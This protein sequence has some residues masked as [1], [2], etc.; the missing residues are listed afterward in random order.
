MK[1]SAK[2]LFIMFFIPLIGL[3]QQK[4]TLIKKVDSLRIKA[5]TLKSDR[6]NN[7]NPPGMK[8][9]NLILVP[10]LL[11]RQITSNRVLSCPFIPRKKTG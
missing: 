9:V 7:I 8:V 5:D 10:I 6:E 1:G 2:V 11:Y 4:D 3:S